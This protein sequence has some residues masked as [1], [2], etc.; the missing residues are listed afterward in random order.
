MP[1]LNIDPARRRGKTYGLMGLQRDNIR[2]LHAYVPG[3]QPADTDVVKLNTNENP[4]PPADAV[5]D[6]V[7]AVSAEQ[8]RRY[9]SPAAAK[10]RQTAAK[11]HGVAAE[12]IIAT[13]GGDELLRL[14]VTVCCEP[15]GPEGRGGV[16]VTEPTYSLYPVLADI[17]DTSVTV[18]KLDETFAVPDDFAAR[19]NDAGCRLAF[20][21]NP[22]APSGRLES[23]GMLRAIA[24]AFDGVLVVDEAYVNFAPR[25][26]ISLVT[27]DDGKPGLDNVLLL[28]SM[29][30]GYS[31]A[32]LRF[33]Y[34]IAA[35]SLI[36]MLDKA[37]DSYNTDAVSQA[38]AVAALEHR[39]EAAKTWQAV[40]EQRAV[41]SDALQQRGYRV[42]PSASNFILTQTPNAKAVYE[43]LK[44]R[45]IFVR[46]F[47]HDG[48]R[49][50]L[51]ITIGT[52]KQNQALL[53]AI[54]TLKD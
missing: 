12:Q 47:D 9:P 28:Q 5:M 13:N 53:D 34:G 40:I 54:D 2:R 30:K 6:A 49:D 4:Y 37:R 3:E 50:K 31:L 48:L 44:A 52:P 20:V 41:V 45:R 51:R 26:A 23:L 29:S 39:D 35:A 1:G 11:V 17:H 21:V 18:V 43:S 36:A 15:A 16:G 22:H 33:G 24:E 46:Y 7:R 38:A 42:F 19:L 14:V 10:F 25:S 32:G 8:L 27:G